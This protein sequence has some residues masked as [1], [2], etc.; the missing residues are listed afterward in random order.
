MFN[1]LKNPGLV[2]LAIVIGIL[3]TNGCGDTNS[4]DGGVDTL[5]DLKSKH[6]SAALY[7]DKS[8]WDLGVFQSGM[9]S[10]KNHEFVVK[11][12]SSSTV[13]LRSVISDCGCITLGKTP[14]EVSGGGQFI[15]PVTVIV[16]PTPGQFRRRVIVQAEKDTESLVLNIIGVVEATA[17]L[18]SD[19]VS[20]DFGSVHNGALCRRTITLRRRD[21]SEVAGVSRLSPGYISIDSISPS[22][23]GNGMD[24]VLALHKV[25]AKKNIARV[26]GMLRMATEHKS[27]KFIQIPFR[28]L[29]LEE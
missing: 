4:W 25:D 10:N 13:P 5:A 17:A 21:L 19:P 18:Y 3:L 2:G 6:S 1:M 28:F 16:P 20:I 12:I 27:H 15:I 29:C 9:T 24:I 14:S 26:S 7:C 23:F 11:N 22:A 8:V